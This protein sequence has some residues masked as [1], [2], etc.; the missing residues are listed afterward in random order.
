TI[1]QIDQD[2]VF[3]LRSRGIDHR[4]ARNLLT[5]AFTADLLGRIKVEALRGRL[6]TALF[7]RLSEAE[8]PEPARP[9]AGAESGRQN[10]ID[11][12]L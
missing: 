3:Y 8:L 7:A 6:E 11:E 1:G 9:Q 2:A 4:T 5:Y 12:G 10:S